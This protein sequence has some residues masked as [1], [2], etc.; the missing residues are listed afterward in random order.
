MHVIQAPHTAAGGI[1]G[2]RAKCAQ[3]DSGDVE[4]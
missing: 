4:D 3:S 2:F 1:S